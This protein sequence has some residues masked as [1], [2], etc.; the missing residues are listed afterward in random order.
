MDGRAKGRLAWIRALRPGHWI[1]NALLLLPLLLAHKFADS[2][3]LVHT[4]LACTAFCLGASGIYILN[5][6]LDVQADRAHERKRSRPFASGALSTTQGL[7]MVAALLP[8][9]LAVAWLVNVKVM[10]LVGAYLLLTIA[11]SLYVKSRLLLDVI[12]LSYLYTHRIICGAVAAQVE[13]TPWLL[14]FSLFFF[15]SL[16]FAK[17]YSELMAIQ[18]AN[19]RQ[20]SGRGY[21][22]DDLEVILSVGPASGYLSVLVFCLYITDSDVA[23]SLYRHPQYLWMI[24]PI[25]LYWI[26][27]VWFFAKR[28]ALEDDPVLFA[29]K[30]RVSWIAGA[31]SAVLVLLAAR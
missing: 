23:K 22:V 18:K 17:R 10:L 31:L 20:A 28:E 13:L 12:L 24:C 1:K 6:L 16:A 27:R 30:D 2:S 29:V 14:A 21:S 8:L 5:D 11:Y 3:R 26:T 25:L 9:A 7:A 19:R 15:L 4:L